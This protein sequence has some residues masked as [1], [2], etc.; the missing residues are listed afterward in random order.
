MGFAPHDAQ[1]TTIEKVTGKKK[2]AI[3]PYKKVK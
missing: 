2:K 3:K 1:S